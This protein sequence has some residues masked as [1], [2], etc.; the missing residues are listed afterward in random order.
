MRTLFRSWSAVQWQA[1]ISMVP[2]APDRVRPVSKQ[3]Y[4]NARLPAV[5]GPLQL[6]NGSAPM[7]AGWSMV[8]KTLL[9]W[10]QWPA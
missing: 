9:S 5:S 4:T 1:E 10:S 8:A 3:L 6:M 7:V 2:E